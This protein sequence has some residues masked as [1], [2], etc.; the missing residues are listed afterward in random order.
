MAVEEGIGVLGINDFY[1]TSAYRTFH[2][3]AVRYRIFPLFNVEFMGLS[4]QD[5]Q[6]GI[7]INDPNNPGRIY[8]SGKGLKFP[9][10]FQKKYRVLIEQLIE[11]NNSHSYQMIRKVNEI[12][13]KIDS[14]FDIS[15]HEISRNYAV[16]LVRERHIAKMLRIKILETIHKTEEQISF[17]EK[18]YEGKRVKAALD[19]P[20]ALENEIRSNLLKAGGSA[21]VPEDNSTFLSIEKIVEIIRSGGGIPCYPVLLDNEKG[22]S[23]EFEEN[24][25]DLLGRLEGM[26]IRCIELI[27]ARNSYEM[28]KQFTTYFSQYGFVILYG[29]EH[30]TPEMVPL[31]V[32][33]RDR[34]LDNDLKNISFD[35]ACLIAAHQYLNAKGLNDM[36]LDK[37]WEPKTI[38]YL[39]RLGKA[40][41]FYFLTMN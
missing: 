3:L 18:I 31:K 7:R 1:T 13:K 30:N 14:P 35:G 4:L 39:T 27:P 10:A 38:H 26:K 33:C 25:N 22:E 8:L 36:Y 40:V 2:D 24:W 23:T 16:K 21:Y 15:E 41:I 32:S 20:V 34:E 9:D 37:V 11:A 6:Q 29:T 12:L 19:N 28:V 5:Q 17:L